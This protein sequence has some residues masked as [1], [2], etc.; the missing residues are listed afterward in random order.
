M[1]VLGELVFNIIALLGVQGELAKAAAL[2][3]R[4]LAIR[5]TKLGPDHPA[6]ASALNNLAMLFKKQV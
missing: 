3:K 1:V 2:H 6:V 4:S 5:E